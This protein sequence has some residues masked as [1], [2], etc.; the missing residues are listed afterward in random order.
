MGRGRIASFMALRRA[1]WSRD[2]LYLNDALEALA[3]VDLSGPLT[4]TG[5]RVG[6]SPD[7]NVPY[8]GIYMETVESFRRGGFG[9]YLVQDLIRCAYALGSIPCAP[10]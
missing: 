5:V 3:M 1:S 4:S 6:T 8:P 2:R 7:D 10:L 9:S